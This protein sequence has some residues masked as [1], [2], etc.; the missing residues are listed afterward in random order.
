[1]REDALLV[2]SKGVLSSNSLTWWPSDAQAV[3]MDTPLTPAPTTAIR[4][5]DTADSP[6]DRLKTGICNNST[7]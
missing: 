3:A 4:F 7:S 1:M 5:A 2:W 6:I